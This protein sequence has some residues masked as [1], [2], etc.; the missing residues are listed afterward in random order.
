MFLF[1]TE[2]EKVSQYKDLYL[3]IWWLF[4]FWYWYKKYEVEKSK[5]ILSEFITNS[6]H[7]FNTVINL[8][9][10]WEEWVKHGTYLSYIYQYFLLNQQ[11]YIKHEDWRIIEKIFFKQ[12]EF[13]LSKQH[14]VVEW[15][16]YDYINN[17]WFS[18]N[19]ISFIESIFKEHYKVYH[20]YYKSLDDWERKENAKLRVDMIKNML[21]INP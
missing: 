1:L 14:E 19:Y 8:Y 3:L 2:P 13:I 4:A 18:E 17:I 20:D 16:L 7:E 9:T 15:F 5:K 6:N 10:N 21:N 12:S 11:W